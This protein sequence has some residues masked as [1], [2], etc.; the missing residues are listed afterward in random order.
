MELALNLGWAA[1]AVWMVCVWLRRTPSRRQDRRA[2][3]VA[4]AMAILILL[5][6]ISMTDDLAAAQC[7]AV[8][9]LSVRRSHDQDAHNPHCIFPAAASL[10]S[11]KFS[12]L[13]LQTTGKA[14]LVARILV[15]VEN[16]A[17]I[18]IDN[19]PPPAAS[20]SFAA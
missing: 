20:F 17:L 13:P 1:L 18:A 9:D 2:Q 15:A 7:P 19:R 11:V 4:L 6:A 3:M 8:L 12:C 10:P 5:P 16:P 14:A